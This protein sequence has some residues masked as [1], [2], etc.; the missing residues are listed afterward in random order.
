MHKHRTRSMQ[1]YHKVHEIDTQPVARLTQDALLLDIESMPLSECE[2]ERRRLLLEKTRAEQELVAAK[3]QQDAGG[4]AILGLR[5]QGYCNRLSRLN[6]RAKQV[7]HDVEFSAFRQAVEELLDEDTFQR[8]IARKAELRRAM[9][10]GG[11]A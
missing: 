6:A 8:I 11:A 3:R 4:I 1:R 10:A 9:L 7:R 2:A 5:I